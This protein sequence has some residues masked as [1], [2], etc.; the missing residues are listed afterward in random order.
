M[1]R[2]VFLSRFFAVMSANAVCVGNV[3]DELRKM[4]NE[5][6]I[7]SYEEK[8]ENADSRGIHIIANTSAPEKSICRRAKNIVNIVCGNISCNF[9]KDLAELYYE[10]LCQMHKISPI[11]TVVGVHFPFESVQA[12][13]KFKRKYQNVKAVIYELDSAVDGIRMSK[14]PIFY[15]KAVEKWLSEK[16][17]IADTVI[18]MKSHEEY[19]K[20][21]FEKRFGDKLK[22]ADIPV[23]TEKPQNKQQ[24]KKQASMIYSG[25]LDK[26]YRS[27]SY[28]LSV[29]RELS[30]KIEFEFSFY[31]KGNCEEK[32]KSAV[33]EIEGIRRCGYVSQ[34][35]LEQVTENADILV[36]IGN[37]VSKSVP[38]KMIAYMSYGKPII[39][40]SSQ[41][42]DICKEYLY[43]YPLSLVIDQTDKPETA[44]KKIAEFIE[45]TK[46]KREEF[47]KIRELFALSDPKY[48]ANIICGND[49]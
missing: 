19:W 47:D 5:V 22:I 40:F 41:K 44:C 43:R 26:K 42:D 2:I 34:E 13:I 6:D 49:E 38:S 24:E 1:S 3:A 30:K 16:Y 20:G 4:G 39:H 12:L 28:L 25:L 8:A 48:S 35:K 37:S 46:G 32:I 29:L 7:I 14:I 10:K 9:D 45:K 27:P 11:D 31:S 21:K 15:N 17:E 36:N 33:N 23:L 18:V